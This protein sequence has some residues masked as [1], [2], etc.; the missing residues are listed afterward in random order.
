MERS[1]ITIIVL[2][3]LVTL[4][5]WLIIFYWRIIIVSVLILL[6]LKQLY[7]YILHRIYCS[8]CNRTGKLKGYDEH[9]NIH[10][11]GDDDCYICNGTG[12]N[13]QGAQKQWFKVAQIADGQLQKLHL[14]E[15]LLLKKIAR[16]RKKM[17]FSDQ[18]NEGILK[19]FS[20]ILK[21]HNEQ[22][23]T[24][25][26]KIAA[27]QLAKRQA[28]INAHNIHLMVIVEKEQIDI[29]Q[30]EI[31]EL[32]TLNRDLYF[33]KDATLLHKTDFIPLL[34]GHHYDHLELLSEPMRNNIEVAIEE[35]RTV[36]KQYK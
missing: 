7:N 24:L 30:W 8:Y 6:L 26:T 20:N 23:A 4:F 3:L 13:P 28:L 5:I 34:K 22:L 29:E 16:Y 31:Q 17:K 12:K 27:Y 2:A 35:Y 14:E 10:F 21:Q 15:E 19:S 18:T 36:L 25:E 1:A 11:H 9:L 33:V 32:N